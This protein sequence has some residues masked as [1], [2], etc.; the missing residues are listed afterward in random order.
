MK[1]ISG[2]VLYKELIQIK[3]HTFIV[4][5]NNKI[6]N[7]TL[8]LSLKR[9]SSERPFSFQP[10]Q[11]AAIS[12]Y[13]GKK[14]SPARCFSIVSSPTDQ[15]ILEFSTRVRGR[16]TTALAKLEPDDVVNVYGPYGGFVFDL[17]NDQNAIFIAGGIGITPFM[18]M[19][20]YAAKLNADNDVNL[21]Y[22]VASSDDIPF[23][24]EL[25]NIEKN[26]SNLKTKFVIGH[27]EPTVDDK[28]K[29]LTGHIDNQMLASHIK[30]NLNDYKFYICGPPGFMTAIKDNLLAAGVA[31]S[32]ILTEAFTQASTRQSGILRS[33]PANIYALGVIGVVL[34]SIIVMA[35]D[36]LKTLPPVSKVAPTK[37]VPFL[38][39][40]AR[41][42]QLDQLVNTISPSASV[43][44][45]PSKTAT[46]TYSKSAA[47]VT[48][49]SAP[50]TFAPIY[51]APKPTTR[52][53]R[54][55]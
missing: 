35:G 2:N 55:P 39:T 4:K 14:Q 5:E 47:P 15:N 12:F 45:L 7:S 8:L 6:T 23:Q 36:L 54:I 49:S 24:E 34:S 28:D 53:S 42:Q 10:G 52:V 19:I 1:F 18:S 21:F 37:T 13:H 43:I 3:M 11:Y 27:G 46:P 50:P 41:Q 32:A 44:T 25:N 16:F 33:W 30:K 38:I 20:R 26:H 17:N 9:E 40:N 51:L 22:S 48:N 29:Y 31:K